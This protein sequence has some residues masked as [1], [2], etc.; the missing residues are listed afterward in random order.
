MNDPLFKVTR[1]YA[2]PPP[3]PPKRTSKKTLIM[4]VVIAI[5]VVVV[6]AEA[7]IIV[8]NGNNNSYNPTSTPTPNP[9]STPTNT[10]TPTPTPTPTETPIVTPTPIPE[11]VTIQ[12]ASVNT[13]R[14]IVTI[15]AQQTEG[16]AATPVNM[17]IKASNGTTVATVQLGIISPALTD[18]KMALGT[19]YTIPSATLTT[20]LSPGNYTA[21]LIT[22]AGSSFASPSFVI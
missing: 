7:F 22:I 8:N 16:T 3:P 13:E 11:T 15:Y 1:T 12:A 19:L 18:A 21:I 5:L 6:L 17:I 4:I 2:P 14:T 10:P 9:T 20:A